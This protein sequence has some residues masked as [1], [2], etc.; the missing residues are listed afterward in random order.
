MS[1]TL[2]DTFAGLSVLVTGH[3]GFKGSWLSIWLNELG[4]KVIGYSLEPPTTPSNFD[5]SRLSDR[6]VDIRDDILNLDALQGAIEEHRPQ[7]VFHLA[8]QAI[9]L[10]SFDEPK[11]TLDTNVAGT[12][13]VLEAIRRSRCVKAFVCITSDKCYENRNWLWGYRENDTLGGH[14]PYSASKAMAE[15]AVASY[16]RSFFPGEKSDENRVAVASTR[17]GNVIGGGDFGEFRLVPDCMRALLSEETVRVRNPLSVRPWQ[18]V[19]EP[20]SGYL[21]LA[22]KL[23]RNG[24]EYAGAWNF[25]PSERHEVTAGDV[26]ERIIELWGSGSMARAE[27]DES[28]RERAFLRLNWDKAANRLNWRPVYTWEEALGETVNWFKIHQKHGAAAEPSDMY[29]VC[30]AHVR[31]YTERAQELGV[32]WAGQASRAMSTLADRG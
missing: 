31:D 24:D 15:L 3:T 4:A 14:D 9:V 12:V 20:L 16:R 23:L 32:E 18:H 22:A 8:A 1:N 5:L 11:A 29:D 10:K 28:G 6:I 27:A 26:V 13:N 21:W 17:A 2:Q 25:G 7:A 19:L 30:A